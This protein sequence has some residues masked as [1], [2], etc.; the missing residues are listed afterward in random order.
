MSPVT[1]DDHAVIAGAHF[2]SI[3][4]GPAARA[5][6][7][8]DN[9]SGVVV[10]L[11]ALR[12]LAKSKFKP[13]NTIEFHFYGGEEGGLLG[14]MDIFNN[15]KATSKSVLGFVNQ[16][17]AGYS[18]SG[19]ISI[20][21]DYVDPVFTAYVRMIAEAYTGPTTR[22]VCGYGCSDHAPAFYNG[23]RGSSS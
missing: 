20:F 6:G 9:A 8:D 16:D 5:P 14:A 17:M 3:A 13:H 2:D 12:V 11:E 19:M 22:D 1:T 10:V 4:G 23:F 15:Y 7:A 21:T 18:P